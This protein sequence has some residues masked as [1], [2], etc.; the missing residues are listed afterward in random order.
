MDLVGEV[1]KI[2]NTRAISCLANC[3]V[4]FP[5]PLRG[6]F[7]EEEQADKVYTKEEYI[8][9]VQSSKI[10]Q[11]PKAN[12]LIKKKQKQ[13]GRLKSGCWSLLL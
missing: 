11:A 13:E 7:S 8:S 10:I 3:V 6:C 5:S 9:A 1:Y 12:A 2:I 4:N